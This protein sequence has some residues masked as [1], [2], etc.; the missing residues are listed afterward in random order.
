M[1]QK[2][3]TIVEKINLYLRKD[4]GFHLL[5]GKIEFIRI[6]ILNNEHSRASSKEILKKFGAPVS[7]GVVILSINDIHKEISKLKSKSLF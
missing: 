5:H 6:K 2:K 1:T 3:Y 7:R 4:T